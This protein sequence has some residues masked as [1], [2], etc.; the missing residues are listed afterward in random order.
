MISRDSEL[1]NFGLCVL[2]EAK[3]PKVEPFTLVTYRDI[4][5]LL[6]KNGSEI[7]SI[8]RIRSEKEKAK[9]RNNFLLF[10]I[11]RNCKEYPI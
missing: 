5:Y 4:N 3:Y 2:I 6:G 11:K 7:S 1:P 8:S 9:F 10:N